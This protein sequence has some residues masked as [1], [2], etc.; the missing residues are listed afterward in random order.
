M[1]AASG[2]VAAA[3]E[4]LTLEEALGLAL[5]NNPGVENASI[6]IEKVGDQVSATRKRQYP[7]FNTT[8]RGSRNF[9]DESY[10]I[11]QGAL[12]T[13]AGTPVPEQNTTLESKEDYSAQFEVEVRQP[14]TKLYSIGLNLDKLEVDRKIGDQNLRSKQQDVALKVKQEYYAIL[15][16]QSALE[17]TEE[18]IAFYTSLVE[19]VGNRVTERT[20]LEYQLLD[21]EARLAQA[22]YDELEQT[23]DLADH[24]ERLNQL[25]GRDIDTPFMVAH[26][27]D[28]PSPVLDPEQAEAQALAQRPETREARLKLAQAELERRIKTSDYI[29]TVDLKASYIKL[30]NT[31]FIPD[32]YFFV[33]VVARWEFFDW[34]RREDEISK[35][36]RSV[37]EAR[38]LIRE[39]DHQVAAQ[40]NQR[41]RDL[42]NAKGLVEVTAMAQKAAREKLRVTMNKYNEEAALLDDVLEA[43][44]KLAKANSDHEEA[45]LGVLS[46]TAELENALGED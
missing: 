16:T 29:P 8:V 5:T 45:T 6:D 3:G 27:A 23:N 11:D 44:S 41:I 13:I 38:N 32:D 14:L 30:A 39:A 7:A 21:A 1:I 4:V 43:E 18:S 25:M 24:K 26:V 9:S 2:P 28:I 22:R 19:I 33:G 12:G 31:E 40:V 35:A 10:T 15:T 36:R 37:S 20:A 34:G 42:Q 17:A 46:A